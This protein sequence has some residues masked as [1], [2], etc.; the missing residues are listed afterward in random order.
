MCSEENTS[1]THFA[2][3]NTTTEKASMHSNFQIQY[4]K[5]AKS[6]RRIPRRQG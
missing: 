3:T 6:S 5:N 1:L 2:K 4:V